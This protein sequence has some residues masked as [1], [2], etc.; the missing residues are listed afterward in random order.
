M[1]AP[2]SIATQGNVIG[3]VMVNHYLCAIKKEADT[4]RQQG[5]IHIRK[6]DLMTD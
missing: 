4:Q 2:K 5:L 1:R 6:V 3:A